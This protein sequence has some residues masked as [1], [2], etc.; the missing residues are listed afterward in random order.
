[1]K[2]YILLIVFS[3]NLL[4]C[5]KHHSEGGFPIPRKHAIIYKYKKDY[6]KN[7]CVG[8][9]QTKTKILVFPGGSDPG[10]DTSSSNHITM[11]NGYI[12]EWGAFSYG[13][14]SAYLSITRKEWNNR[15]IPID[16]IKNYII[17]KD[18]FIEYYID[19]KDTTIDTAIRFHLN[20]YAST[21]GLT[22]KLH[23]KRIK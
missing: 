9:D 20:D 7:V 13:Y 8:M 2:Q 4:A 3:F 11:S 1:M 23:L 17:D 22:N 6:E 18:P 5:K 14:N 12:L 15:T 16:S 21:D 19:M 10:S